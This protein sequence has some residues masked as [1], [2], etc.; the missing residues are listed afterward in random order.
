MKKGLATKNAYVDIVMVTNRIWMKE[1]GYDGQIFVEVVR[2]DY[3]GR[4]KPRAL[5]SRL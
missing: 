3:G 5:T 1:T 2:L 4:Y